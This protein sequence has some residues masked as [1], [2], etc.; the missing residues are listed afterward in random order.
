MGGAV[1]GPA[2]HAGHPLGTDAE[3][4][5]EQP[6]ACLPEGPR[7]PRE[8]MR[9]GPGLAGGRAIAMGGQGDRSGL[10]IRASRWR[11]AGRGT[12][13]RKGDWG[14]RQ[15]VGRSKGK[16]GRDEGR[17]AWRADP[18]RGGVLTAKVAL[19]PPP[20]S[21]KLLISILTTQLIRLHVLNYDSV[22]RWGWGSTVSPH[23]QAPREPRFIDQ[24]RH[25]RRPGHRLLGGR[26]KSRSKG[27][28]RPSAGGG[29]PTSSAQFSQVSRVEASP[30]R[31]SSLRARAC[32]CPAHRWRLCTVT[33]GRL[34]AWPELPRSGGHARTRPFPRAGRLRVSLVPGSL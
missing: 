18:C 9:P 27:G 28:R 17:G 14:R 2:R 16:E 31:T 21:I 13:D 11:Q 7:G 30:L 19:H 24:K 15:G 5:M 22:P 23:P 29:V 8:A 6:R 10:R 25:T 3:Q 1:A 4:E 33:P 26:D 34:G 32:P 20:V 12:E